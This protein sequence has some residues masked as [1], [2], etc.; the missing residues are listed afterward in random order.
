VR[1]DSTIGKIAGGLIMTLVVM[2]TAACGY[3]TPPAAD[4]SSTTI[5]VVLPSIRVTP[6]PLVPTGFG[7]LIEPPSTP[8]TTEAVPRVTSIHI[9]DLE[10]VGGHISWSFHVETTNSQSIR[11]DVEI[12]A[13]TKFLYGGAYFLTGGTSY[14]KTGSTT[15]FRQL[16]CPGSSI[17]MRVSWLGKADTAG[18]RCH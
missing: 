7:T 12:L 11:V 9:T 18:V 3:A 16:D 10:Y 13:G 15:V 14:T 1:I 5:H 2:L 17:E 6:G 8:S 4:P